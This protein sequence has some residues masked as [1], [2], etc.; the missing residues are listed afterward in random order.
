MEKNCL[1]GQDSTTVVA[2]SKKKL[3]NK[4]QRHTIYTHDNILTDYHNG[5]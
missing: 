3:T 4:M 2:P 5:L 1:E